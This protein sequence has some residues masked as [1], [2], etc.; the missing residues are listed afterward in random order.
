M[1][2]SRKRSTAWPIGEE[3]GDGRW[4]SPSA[5]RNRDPI[6]AALTRVLPKKGLVLEIGSGTGQHV[7][8]FASHLPQLAW[9]PSDP[10]A[11]FR[12]SI[13]LWVRHERLA[14]V[15]GPVALDLR[16]RPW[17]VTAADA[18][19]CI[20]V[21]HVSPWEATLALLD[22]AAE[23]LPRGG[24][25]YLYGPYRRQD[26]PTAPGNE[27]FDASLRAHDPAW[28]LREIEQVSEA[29]ERCGLDLAEIADMPA[30]N[31]SLIFLRR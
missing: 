5:E 23:I 24:V 15:R 30:N 10:D 11:G 6:L 22:G 9:Q 19:V 20:N 16:T 13:E 31:S 2:A 4:R 25:L 29:A 28:G 12:R 3:L 17:P 21:V 18:I 26:R 27:A 7:A 8:H 1:G 14:N